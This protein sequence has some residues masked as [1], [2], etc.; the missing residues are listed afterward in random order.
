ML[1]V[2]RLGKT[3]RVDPA[4]HS[5]IKEEILRKRKTRERFIYSEE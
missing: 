3:L 5:C 4:H 2:L 1:L